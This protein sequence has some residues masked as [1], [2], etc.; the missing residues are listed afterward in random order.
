MVATV[1]RTAATAGGAELEEPAKGT[2]LT[3]LL[4]RRQGLQ[5]KEPFETLVAYHP[6]GK[7]FWHLED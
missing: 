1:E 5:A 2:L 3:Q 4:A 7:P 6:K